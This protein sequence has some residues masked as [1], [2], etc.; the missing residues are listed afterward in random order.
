MVLVI[1]PFTGVAIELTLQQPST[2][3]EETHEEGE[4]KKLETR[5][6]HASPEDPPPR[7]EIVSVATVASHHRSWTPTQ[8]PPLHPAKYS[9]RRLR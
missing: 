7:R 1:A 6:E 8:A 5:A 4:H 3:S 2:Q 9:E